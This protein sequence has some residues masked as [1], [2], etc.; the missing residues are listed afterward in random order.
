M[1]RL[2]TFV[3]VI[4]FTAVF[5]AYASV[6]EVERPDGVRRALETYERRCGPTHPPS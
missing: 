6:A 4:A 1:R 2:A 5:V 3:N